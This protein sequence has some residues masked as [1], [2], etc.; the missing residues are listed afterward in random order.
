MINHTLLCISRALRHLCIDPGNIDLLALQHRDK[1]Y[2]DLSLPFGYRLGAFFFSKISDA[3]RYIMSQNGHNALLNY[4]DDLIYCAL[5]SKIQEPYQF[6]L[7]LL[8]ELGLDIK[9]ITLT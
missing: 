6:P 1:L 7:T 3:V 2:I 5:P 8:Q 4:I 9:E